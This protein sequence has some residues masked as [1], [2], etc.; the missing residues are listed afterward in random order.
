MNIIVFADWHHKGYAD[1]INESW[2]QSKAHIFGLKF[3]TH[4]FNVLRTFV[5]KH[6][7]SHANIVWLDSIQEP[8][9]SMVHRIE[10][11]FEDT[12]KVKVVTHAI[13]PHLIQSIT[14]LT[15]YTT[16]S[17]VDAFETAVTFPRDQTLWAS[18]G[19]RNNRTPP[20]FP[21]L[22]GRGMSKDL[23][24]LHQVTKYPF[25]HITE[26]W[27]GQVVQYI[28]KYGMVGIATSH[29]SEHTLL[30]R[31]W[32]TY[33][34]TVLEDV[35]NGLSLPDDAQTI[36]FLTLLSHKRNLMLSSSVSNE[37]DIELEQTKWLSTIA[38]LR[39]ADLLQTTVFDSGSVVPLHPNTRQ[40]FRLDSIPS[41]K[42]IKDSTQDVARL[43]LYDVDPEKLPT[44]SVCT[45]T[46]NH[47]LVFPFVINSLLHQSYP[48]HKIEWIVLQ[49]GDEDIK[50]IIPEKLTRKLKRFHME[51]IPSDHGKTMGELRNLVVSFTKEPFVAFMDDDDI[52]F[53]TCLLARIKTLIKY[54][55]DC[56]GS[57]QIGCYD[58]LQEKGSISSDGSHV[59]SE[60]SM[61]FRRS[62]WEDR[63]F[64]QLEQ[65]GE[66]HGFLLGRQR[67]CLSIPY[68]FNMIALSHSTNT[69]GT[70]RMLEGKELL[71]LKQ[72]LTEEELA[73]IETTSKYLRHRYRV[74]RK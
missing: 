28:M 27:D 37:I 54:N 2:F 7:I 50:D 35:D 24:F 51:T 9:Y 10:S 8:L 48:L 52:Y 30:R 74:V 16:V 45:L 12:Q 66:A 23:K 42:L 62:F 56:V 18:K 3:L 59:F 40:T 33:G 26:H 1:A 13:P 11:L 63:G 67:R 57:T 32:R 69:T 4:T 25:R 21:I 38:S 29:R 17:L 46:R 60:A 41:A 39:P 47:R 19:K 65:T 73:L 64:N 20:M 58:L 53:H 55:V 61:A 14:E 71:P 72:I 36:S 68:H 15:N 5:S 44:V 22:V 49:N 70:L 43:P 34:V 6:T 31:F